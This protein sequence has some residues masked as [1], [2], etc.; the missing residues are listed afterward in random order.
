MDLNKAMIIGRLTRDPEG[1][2]TPQGTTV[3]SFSLAT[4]FVW[5]DQSGQQQEKV[6]FHNIVTWRKLAEICAQYL[7]KGKKVFDRIKGF[8]YVCKRGF[9][10]TFGD[11][12]IIS[13]KCKLFIEF[14][15]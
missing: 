6:E 5:T 15:V 10:F 7:K 9:F 2:T 11:R 13:N 14:D 12:G 3:T 1:K 8:I 4:N